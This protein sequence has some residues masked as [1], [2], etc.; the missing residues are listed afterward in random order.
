[1]IKNNK[2]KFFFAD[3]KRLSCCRFSSLFFVDVV[4][5]FS[6]LNANLDVGKN[7]SE[8]K[9]KNKEERGE[10]KLPIYIIH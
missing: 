3:F 1:M 8:K 9:K 10:K 5:Q 4:F 2:K 7:R 6:N